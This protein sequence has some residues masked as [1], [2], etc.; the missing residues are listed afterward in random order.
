MAPQPRN[1]TEIG[2][3]PGLVTN[4]DGPDV[5][6]GAAEVQINLMSNRVGELTTRPGLTQVQFEGS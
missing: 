5:P 3:F 6:S 4:A 2:D 1:F